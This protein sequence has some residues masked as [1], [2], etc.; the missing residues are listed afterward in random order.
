MSEILT[1]EEIGALIQAIT[2]SE[3]EKKPSDFGVEQKN[4]KT[5]DFKKPDK[6]SKDQLKT[7]YEIHETFSRL[8]TSDFNNKLRTQVSSQI[9]YVD[10]LSYE[11]FIRSIP[12]LTA[13]SSITLSPLPS[14][15]II[16]IDPALT[17]S[18]IDRLL[19]GTGDWVKIKR[20]FTESEISVLK[21]ILNIISQE[22]KESWSQILEIQP[23][24][25]RVETNTNHRPMLS[26]SEI[27]V[28]ITLEIK[29][30]E[31]EGTLNLVIPYSQV[32]PILKRFSPK[33]WDTETEKK[34]TM[35]GSAKVENYSI[36]KIY[37]EFPAGSIYISPSIEN[38]SQ[39]YSS[40]LKE[41]SHPSHSYEV[42]VKTN[43]GIEAKKNG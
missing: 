1:S 39:E 24:I 20:E 18:M 19:G 43:A 29:I 14:N 8:F 28:L 36:L 5:Y 16:E 30:L 21:Y 33:Y 27:I 35:E 31:I 23:V 17:F 2:R 26:S 38:I 6:F 13:L 4:I 40:L 9:A 37:S 25:D 12:T 3:N 41:D 7:F 11:E 42:I 32:E 34:Y 15:L 10:Q 22:I